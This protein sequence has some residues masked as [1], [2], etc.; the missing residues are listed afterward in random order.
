[1]SQTLVRLLVHLVFS[2]K[3]RRD[4]I[5]PD[6]EPD[7][8]AYIS[9]I[10]KTLDSVCLEINGTANHIHA[11]VSQSKNLALSSLVMEI[12]KGSSKWIK[13]QGSEFKRFA[14]QQGYGAFSIGESGVGRLRRYIQL[15]KQKHEKHS[16]EDEFI[17]LLKKYNVPYDPRYVWD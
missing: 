14:W 16:F 8:F 17:G 2:T 13:T 1:M 15:Q 7:L 3:N 4:L 9:G 12:K 11:L 6:I 5:T 10:L